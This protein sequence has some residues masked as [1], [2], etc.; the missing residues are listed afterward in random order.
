MVR[1]LHILTAATYGNVVASEEGRS[2]K[3]VGEI[4]TLAGPN[5]Y[6]REPMLVMKLDLDNLA[7]V[8]SCDVPGFVD[9]LLE[10][11][12]GIVEHHCA[13]GRRGG[14]VERLREGTYFGHVVEHVALELT[15]AAGIPVNRGKTTSTPDPRCF[16]VAVAYKSERG[17]KHLLQVAVELVQSVVDDRPYSLDEKL[18][19]ARRLVADYELGPSTR[20]IV[21]AAERRG[22]PWKRLDEGS[23]V[24]LGH[25][26]RARYV[27]ATI[28][29]ST[30]QIGVDLAGDKAKTKRVLS[31]AALPV[32]QGCIASSPDEAAECL[33]GLSA[34]LVVKPLDGNQGRGVSLNLTGREQ[35]LDAFAIAAKVSPD[36]IIEEMYRGHDYRVVMV[37]GRMVAA[38]QRTPAHVWGDGVHS[39]RE[40]IRAA[41]ADPLRGENHEKPL[42]KIT[43]DPI[44]LAILKRNGRTLD[45]VP[46]QGHMVALRESANLS[47]GGSAKD[48]TDVVHPSIR[49]LCERAARVIG[50]DVCGVDLVLPD[51]TEPFSGVGGIVEVNAAPGIRMHHHPSEGQPRDV[52]GAIVDMLYPNGATGRIPLIAITG[53]NGKTTV[54]R[55]IRHVLASTGQV[56]GM[57]TTDGIW[58]GEDEIAR[59]DMTGPWSAGVVLGD[60]TVEVAVLETARGGIVRSGLGYDWADIAVMTNVQAD[61]IGQ[62]GIESIDDILWIKRLVAEQVRA[63]GTLILNADDERLAGVPAHRTVARTPK[64]IVFFGLSASNP[65][66]DAH[67][68]AGGS[69]FVVEGDWIEERTGDSVVRL[70]R[71]A[72]IPA[73]VGGTAEFQIYNV[74]AAAAACRAAGLTDTTVVEGLR[75]FQLDRDSAGRVN[76]YEL[77]GGYVVLDYGHNPAALTAMCAMVSRWG[78]E[79]TTGVVAVPGDRRD[80]LIEDA[81]RAA[82]CGFDR[83]IIRED[84]D[85]RGR[86][87]GEVA[88]LL[89]GV[90][91][92]EKPQLRV[93]VIL[94]ELEAVAAAVRDLES[95]QVVVAFCERLGEVRSWLV[96]QGANPVSVFRPLSPQS[97]GDPVAAG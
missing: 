15:D 86:A 17:M 93:S 56:V 36:V 68:Q 47:T 53:T 92:R 41:N 70:A 5:V 77:N 95:R 12:P 59:G 4:R 81:A 1:F 88:E 84:D 21:E 31:L 73:T 14:F 57:T 72:T 32:P 91:R 43:A 89:A 97:A 37:G 51:I 16:L 25:G 28:A 66:I 11:L 44:V 79:H 22:I 76:L 83:I 82:G 69:A 54:T 61:H 30:R 40:L 46:E 7:G 34:P 39:I 29:D 48:V 33:S 75:S 26:A 24:R 20:A 67:L 3:V 60:A 78:A 90:L 71:T 18:A 50:L 42:T 45:D 23:L 85:R 62:D 63:G 74:L 2:M 49:K 65:V 55:M 9:R 6:S 13:L 35:V 19:E 10:R 96:Q 94:D 80:C 64:R 52:G 87:P 8:E 27:E 58:I 38:A